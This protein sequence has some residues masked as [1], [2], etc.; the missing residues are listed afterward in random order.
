MSSWTRTQT[1]LKSVSAMKL[2]S[3]RSFACGTTWKWQSL[4]LTARLTDMGGPVMPSSSF[5]SRNTAMPVPRSEYLDYDGDD[6]NVTT[7][8]HMLWMVGIAE[9]V[10]VAE[11]MD[12]GGDV[13]CAE[14]VH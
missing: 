6:G 5:L 7:L 8:D 11:A 12:V 4:N 10:T 2:L 3:T 1:S 9:N 14:Y 13:V